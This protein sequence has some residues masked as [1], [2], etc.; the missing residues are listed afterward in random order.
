MSAYKL[1]DTAEIAQHFPIDLNA[2]ATGANRVTLYW[3]SDDG[4]SRYKIFRSTKTGGPYIK[5][6]SAPA[7]SFH[8]KQ[9]NFCRYTD[10][11]LKTGVEY[12]Y[13]VRNSKQERSDEASASPETNAIPWDTDDPK[14]ILA[15]FAAMDAATRRSYEPAAE[16]MQA[17]S[18]DGVVYTSAFNG[19]SANASGMFAGE[20]VEVGSLNTATTDAVAIRKLWDKKN[21]GWDGPRAEDWYP[22]PSDKELVVVVGRRAIPYMDFLTDL[23]LLSKRNGTVRPLTHDADGYSMVRW[24]P[25][26]KQIAYVSQAGHYDRMEQQPTDAYIPWT[27]YV[28]NIITGRRVRLFVEKA[29]PPDRNTGGYLEW[30]P[31]RS[32][33]LYKSSSPR[34]L[35]LLDTNGAKP[36]RLA[37]IGP[38]EIVPGASLA[39]WRDNSKHRIRIAR[40]PAQTSAWTK[41]V[42]WKN[43]T[44][45]V[46][47]VFPHNSFQ[48]QFSRAGHMAFLVP[49]TERGKEEGGPI[50]S[51][52]VVIDPVTC[53][54][55][56]LGV[57]PA[58]WCGYLSWS[59]DG[60]HLIIAQSSTPDEEKQ[61]SID[62]GS[63]PV[64]RF[65]TINWKSRKPAT[66][67]P[68][69]PDTPA[70]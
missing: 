18:P 26:E 30:I 33:L 46:T 10:S 68:I 45:F 38:D 9:V 61:V 37:A 13:Y 12:F 44:P 7:A 57:V 51:Q 22:S 43:L 3:R 39:Y 60:K 66:L 17:V 55:R 70:H 52:L 59:P 24:H 50:P 48:V 42:T 63:A 28:Q 14:Q 49:L 11:G 32:Q 47:F 8:Y 29:L 69:P 25:N 2:V 20:A 16:L 58:E 54:S 6:K 53:K 56:L 21:D 4:A 1:A 64:R 27:V 35:F 67:H 40:L 23:E 31:K 5:I 62:I 36:K 41:P 65:D 19:S 15:S 34:G